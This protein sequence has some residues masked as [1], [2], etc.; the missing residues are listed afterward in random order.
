MNIKSLILGSAAALVAGG[1]AQAA[2]LPV[3]EPVDYV[4]VCDAYGA[5]YFFIPGTD[6]CLKISGKVEFGVS[7]H[8]FS[9]NVARSDRL[10]DFYTETT[11]TFDAK[12][13]TELGT[14]A[15]HMEFD[16]EDNITKGTNT[17]FD[18]AYLQIGGLYAGVTDSLVDFNEGLY[19]DDFGIGHGDLNAIGYVA[20]FG[21]GVSAAIALED[22]DANNAFGTLA[23]AG[24]SMP[25]VA[26]LLKVKQGW[27]T[28]KLGASAYQH[29]YANAAVDTD[30]GFLIGG[31][32]TFNLTDA[33]TFGI[34]G[35]YDKGYKANGATGDLYAKWAVSGGLSF[36]VADNLTFGVD[37]GLID[38][39]DE[40]YKNWGVSAGFGYT[41]VANLEI[42]GKIGYQKTDYDN[43]NTA[44]WDDVAAKMYIKRS[45]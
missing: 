39:I 22:Y 21:N 17:A 34:A 26:A 20:S 37:A 33:L 11:F 27:G 8:G 9:S 30:L 12:E 16:D 4:K 15:L 3:A 43:S 13:E 32:G 41:P 35:G 5:G 36:A 14:L 18:K 31:E 2:D 28:V 29:R 23:G 19:Y 44:D 42:G 40:N 24:M 1:A 45:F 25:S 6:T 7:S 38:Y 10:V